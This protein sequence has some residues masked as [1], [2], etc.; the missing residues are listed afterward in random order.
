MSLRRNATPD[1]S[2]T[3]KDTTHLP[4]QHL[5]A[6]GLSS[7]AQNVLHVTP[8]PVDADAEKRER[9]VK[10]VAG[11]WYPTYTY[12]GPSTARLALSDPEGSDA[13]AEGLLL[14]NQEYKKRNFIALHNKVI[15]APTH[16]S[17]ANQTNSS[18]LQTLE[19][20]LSIDGKY[21]MF[22]FGLG[23]KSKN[24][25]YTETQAMETPTEHEK[26]M[27]SVFGE[28]LPDVDDDL[29]QKDYG[30][31]VVY[32]VKADGNQPG[33]QQPDE[34]AS[35]GYFNWYPDVVVMIGYCIY[36]QQIYKMQGV[37]EKFARNCPIEPTANSSQS[38]WG[39]YWH[40]T[41][42]LSL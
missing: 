40:S 10:R 13:L 42:V 29:K 21:K 27:N 11:K 17:I 20:F 34:Y 2:A 26:G 18:S 25:V 22:C 32:V 1:S 12:R 9:E 38:R 30:Y 19:Q 31:A 16:D 15:K 36:D 35:H 3:T 23:S 37:F 14:L 28:I 33:F 7:R 24:G 8:T 6:I 4:I 39:E 5:A 41:R